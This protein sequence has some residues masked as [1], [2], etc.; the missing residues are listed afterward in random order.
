MKEAPREE[1]FV[2][3]VLRDYSPKRAFSPVLTLHLTME[4]EIEEEPF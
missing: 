1:V 3:C 2:Y 4:R